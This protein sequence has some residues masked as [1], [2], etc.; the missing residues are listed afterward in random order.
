MSKKG[1]GRAERVGLSVVELVRMF[2]DD[3]A[4]EAWFEEQRWPGGARFCPDCGS[5]RYTVVTKPKSMPYRCRSCRAYFSVRKGTVMQSSKLGL[6]TWVIAIYMMTTGIK[7]T[8]SMKLH[9]D[10]GIRQATAWHL[11]Q[12][13]REAFTF[14]NGAKLPGPVEADETYIGG[15]ERNK[16]SRKK[17]RAGR[18][19][20][21]KTA[22]VGVKDRGTRTV[23]AR[24]VERTDRRTLQGFI[25]TNIKPGAAIYTDELAAYRG[26]REFK[27][28]AVKHSVGQ[29]VQEQAHTNGVESFWALLKR[30][31]YGTYHQISPKHLDRYVQEFAG[32]HN[33]RDL[34]TM[35]QMVLLSQGM[36]GKRLRYRELVA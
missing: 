3:A 26:M 6:Q 11:M 13:I 7:G 25:R 34:D 24:V 12:R 22:V 29:Y 14:G 10:L 30:G 9:R 32:R 27:H 33:V 17:L 4:A 15:K 19:P 1:P 36:V 18:G 31:Y 21:G 20:V 35:A 28:H 8:S 16:H 2:P 5:A 23:N